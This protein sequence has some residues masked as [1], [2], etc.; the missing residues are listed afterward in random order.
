M[1][2]P[3]GKCSEVFSKTQKTQPRQQKEEC[4]AASCSND[5][6]EQDQPTARDYHEVSDDVYF[7]IR[8]S[9]DLAEKHQTIANQ[10]KYSVSCPSSRHCFNDSSSHPTSP[11]RGRG[12]SASVLLGPPSDHM[13][14]GLRSTSSPRTGAVLKLAWEQTIEA[15]SSN[16]DGRKGS[17]MMK[18]VNA[19]RSW[20][21]SASISEKQTFA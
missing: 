13:A 5:H 4:Q 14:R 10:Y 16:Q 11:N 20:R 2:K 21:L 17:A 18:L 6:V 8:P 12:C 9:C 3:F 1:K 19:T 15:S 7:D